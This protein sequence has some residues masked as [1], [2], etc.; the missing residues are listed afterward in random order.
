MAT[1]LKKIDVV[2]IG[3]PQPSSLPVHKWLY[4]VTACGVISYS[5]FI[6]RSIRL[7]ERTVVLLGS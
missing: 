2:V 1:N 3:S 7:K 4:G 6:D 5:A